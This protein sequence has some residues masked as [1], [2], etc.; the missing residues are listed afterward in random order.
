MDNGLLSLKNIEFKVGKAFIGDYDRIKP[1]NID[2][3]YEVYYCNQHLRNIFFR[4]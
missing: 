2:G 1:I 3:E 4:V